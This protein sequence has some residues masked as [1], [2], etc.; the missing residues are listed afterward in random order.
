MVNLALPCKC[1]RA[2]AQRVSTKCLRKYVRISA[3]AALQSLFSEKY[4]NNLNGRR[5]NQEEFHA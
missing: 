1:R 3:C 2:A 5:K 4:V